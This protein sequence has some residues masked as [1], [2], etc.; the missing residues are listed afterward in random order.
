MKKC[1]L[2]IGV[3]ILFSCQNDQKIVSG[4]AYNG[5]SIIPDNYS[6]YVNL[7]SKN[8]QELEEVNSN[9]NLSKID[10]NLL[11]A[12][13]F[14]ATNIE[15]KKYNKPYFM[16]SDK[17][18]V[19][20]QGHSNDMVGY[21]FFSHKSPVKEKRTMSDRF[22]KAGLETNR[23]HAENIA[24]Y[25]LRKEETYW[26]AAKRIVNGWMNSPGHRKNILNY[27]FRYLGCGVSNDGKL[28]PYKWINSSETDWYV[29]Y[30][31]TQNFMD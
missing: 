17:L 30:L 2:I 29:W 12:A 10:N 8:F 6:N 27:R 18:F 13:I 31:S 23:Y 9:I 28:I 24:K 14:H 15:R 26:S 3:F 1:F 25:D 16:H 19:V 7:D 4:A 20:A 5:D 11:A 22:M 21:N